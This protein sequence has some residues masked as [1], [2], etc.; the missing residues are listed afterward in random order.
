MTLLDST[1]KADGFRMPGEFEPQSHVW[2]IWP[3][4]PDVWRN[5]AI[6]G[7]RAFVEVATDISRFTPITM[8]TSADHCDP[9]AKTPYHKNVRVKLEKLEEA[10]F[11]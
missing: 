3:V 5:Q 1:P 11:A 8:L 9:L 4:R 7:Q 2:M 6:P 10:I